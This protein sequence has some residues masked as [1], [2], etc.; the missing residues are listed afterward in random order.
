MKSRAQLGTGTHDAL[1]PACPTS[2]VV[3]TTCS[4]SAHIKLQCTSLILVNLLQLDEVNRLAGTCWQ[5]AASWYN[6]QVPQLAAS[7][8]YFW[9][10]MLCTQYLVNRGRRRSIIGGGAHIH[11]LVFTDCKNNR[12]QKKL[13]MHNVNT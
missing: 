12:F 5:L 13:M 10:C 8:W 9:L 11:I 1:R 7:L 3:S 6:P 4:Q 2:S